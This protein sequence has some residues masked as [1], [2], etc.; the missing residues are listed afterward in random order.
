VTVDTEDLIRRIRQHRVEQGLSPESKRIDPFV[1]VPLAMAMME[2]LQPFIRVAI[3][4]T[5]LLAEGVIHRID[6]SKFDEYREYARLINYSDATMCK[7]GGSFGVRS[8]L[9][10]MDDINLTAEED[11]HMADVLR[12][13][14]FSIEMM[15]KR[16]DND[17]Y[18]YRIKD[19]EQS[20]AHRRANMT[21]YKRLRTDSA[22]FDAAY[23]EA[24]RQYNL[25][26]GD[27]ENYECE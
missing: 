5:A 16:T 1:S 25:I 6:T 8:M 7:L 26:K 11:L 9:R 3:K 4:Y 17:V 10:V 12:N 2:R 27:T 23:A 18:D 13:A 24:R 14:H 22:A 15:R 19:L 20:K 21:E